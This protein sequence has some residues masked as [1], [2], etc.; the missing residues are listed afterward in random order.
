MIEK[1]K[2]PDDVVTREGT[3]LISALTDK[4]NELVDAYN[5]LEEERH[6]GK[7]ANKAPVKTE[8]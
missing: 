3:I 7:A 2:Y 5:K 8:L 4:I 1:L 6:I